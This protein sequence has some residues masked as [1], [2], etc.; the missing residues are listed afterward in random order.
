MVVGVKLC[1]FTVQKKTYRKF[2]IILYDILAV[3][4]FSEFS[5]IFQ[6]T[7]KISLKLIFFCLWFLVNTNA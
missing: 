3:H 4:L 1:L 2:M 6:Y 7:F 5:Q